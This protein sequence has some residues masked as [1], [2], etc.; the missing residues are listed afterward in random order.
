MLGV[1]RTSAAEQAALTQTSFGAA[2][3]LN[4]WGG[5]ANLVW[6]IQAQLLRGLASHNTTAVR[7]GFDVMWA[8]V[9]VKSP[10]RNGQG[11]MPD[12]AYH[13]HGQQPLNFAYG[14]D[15]LQDMLLFHA[16]A[17]GTAY[18]LSGA[19]VDILARFM[20]EG[21]AHMSFNR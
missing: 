8:D 4:Q 7:Q 5:G 21:N 15:W 17:N 9:T 6:M 14:A 3:W 11:I 12:G 10:S 18:D 16:C 20:A 1:N 2:W 19:Q 13:F